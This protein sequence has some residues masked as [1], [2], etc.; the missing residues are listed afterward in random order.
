VKEQS[1][2]VCVTSAVQGE[3]KT[4]TVINLGY[5]FARDLGRRT[6]LVDCDFKRPSLNRYA[7]RDSGLGLAD[8]LRSGMSVDDCLFGIPEIPCWI[9]PVGKC[10]DESNELLK[11]NRLSDIFDQLR[12]RFEYIFINAPPILPLADTNVITGY[13]DVLLLVVR[14]ASTPQQYVKHALNTLMSGKPTHL[15]FNAAHGQYLPYYIHDYCEP[16]YKGA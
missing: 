1:T 13:V 15:I 5:T 6:V 8:C 7:G 9:M 4:T 16:V 2:I 12:E 3:G 14:A 10:E 11:A